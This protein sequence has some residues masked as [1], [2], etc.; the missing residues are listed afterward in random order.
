MFIINRVYIT[1]FLNVHKCSVYHSRMRQSLTTTE[2]VRLQSDSGCTARERTKTI[3]EIEKSGQSSRRR[4]YLIVG[5][6]AGSVAALGRDSEGVSQ[7][8]D[9]HWR[10]PQLLGW[11]FMERRQARVA[12]CDGC[13][14]RGSGGVERDPLVGLMLASQQS[15]PC[16]GHNN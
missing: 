12:S 16:P 14:R 6:R 13:P 9:G 11:S 15:R 1:A 7:M 5:R 8:P 2:T 3:T 4:F 10:Q